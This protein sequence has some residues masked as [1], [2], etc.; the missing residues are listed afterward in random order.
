MIGSTENLIDPGTGVVHCKGPVAIT[1]RPTKGSTQREITRVNHGLESAQ[2]TC[3]PGM[4]RCPHAQ[5][6][7]RFTAPLLFRC[8]GTHADH[9]RGFAPP[10]SMG[11]LCFRAFVTNLRRTRHLPAD[12]DRHDHRS[13][14]A[15][16]RGKFSCRVRR[17]RRGAAPRRCD[18]AGGNARLTEANPLLSDQR[19]TGRPG[20]ARVLPRPC[21]CHEARGAVLK[22]DPRPARLRRRL[23]M[24]RRTARLDAAGE[25]TG[26][27]PG[28]ALL[29]RPWDLG[30]PLTPANDRVAAGSSP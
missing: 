24:L 11:L 27:V 12:P 5:P 16:K 4:S 23:P 30:L 28:A 15:G 22:R 21:P 26:R 9:V 20:P 29:A 17:R 25:V 8:D 6:R 2:C 18:T 13:V 10:V 14:H 3:S 1:P 19:S 7:A